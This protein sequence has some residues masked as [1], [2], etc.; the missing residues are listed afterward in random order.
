MEDLMSRL[1]RS[2]ESGDGVESWAVPVDVV[3][4]GDNIVVHASLPGVNRD[5][6]Q[7]LIEDDVLT[8][9]GETAAE[10][11]PTRRLLASSAGAVRSI[12]LSACLI[13]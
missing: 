8:V 12:G 6:I 11:E 10:H 5:D 3:R 7:V 4:D 9:K 13:R 2:G 1:W